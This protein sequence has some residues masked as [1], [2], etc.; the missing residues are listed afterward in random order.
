MASAQLL[1]GTASLLLTDKG[2]VHCGLGWWGV[3]IL[4]YCNL[5]LEVFCFD[6]MGT[7]LVF[8]SQYIH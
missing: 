2:M 3:N 8:I 4:Y 6:G 5:I 7:S 1:E